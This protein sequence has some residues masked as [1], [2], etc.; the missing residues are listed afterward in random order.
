MAQDAQ[1][2]TYLLELLEE[3]CLLFTLHNGTH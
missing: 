2:C 3:N 1:T